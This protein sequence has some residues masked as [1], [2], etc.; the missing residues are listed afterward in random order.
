MTFGETLVWM[1]L[2]VLCALYLLSWAG[3]LKGIRRE[4][5]LNH[6][7]RARVVGKRRIKDENGR[8]VEDAP[9]KLV[10]L[11]EF[12]NGRVRTLEENEHSALSRE[13]IRLSAA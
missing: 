1:V 4:Y 10:F 2:M 13:L 6:C 11:V 5:V 3:A 9:V 12:E 8:P 7:V